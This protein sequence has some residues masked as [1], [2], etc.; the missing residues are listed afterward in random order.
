MRR[1][2]ARGERERVERARRV[3]ALGLQRVVCD[4]KSVMPPTWA[5]GIRVLMKVVTLYGKPD[6]H[7]CVEA[8][9]VLQELRSELGFE[10]LEVDITTDEALHRAYFE[11]IPV[12]VLGDEELFEYFVDEDALRR[13]LQTIL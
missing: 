5:G 3:K 9:K 1:E 8:Q 2:S 12:G 6:C 4:E 13:R 10:L 7:L 11:R